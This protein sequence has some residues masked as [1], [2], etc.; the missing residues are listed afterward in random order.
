MARHLKVSFLSAD[1]VHVEIIKHKRSTRRFGSFWD[2]LRARFDALNANQK[3]KV[4]LISGEFTSETDGETTERP[5]VKSAFEGA[6][7]AVE[8]C[9][10]A[11]ACDIRVAAAGILIDVKQLASLG[12]TG[13]RALKRL[14][15]T[16]GNSSWTNAVILEALPFN[17]A[18]AFQNRIIS[19]VWKDKDEAILGAITLGSSVCTRSVESIQHAKKM[20][21]AIRD[22]SDGKIPTEESWYSEEQ[23]K[24]DL[25][26]ALGVGLVGVRALL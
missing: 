16:A 1:F 10:K 19:R 22:G 26:Q 17:A 12:S 15:W 21:V 9:T 5:L 25:D 24:R 18:E 7:E 14:Y 2:E 13:K 6:V 3:L 23:A 20:W 4:I 8:N 11:S